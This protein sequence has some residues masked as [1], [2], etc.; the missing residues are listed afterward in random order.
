MRIKISICLLFSLLGVIHTFAQEKSIS[1]TIKNPQG[2]PQQGVVVSLKGDASRTTQTNAKGEYTI[3]AKSTDILVFSSLGMTTIERTVGEA[4]TIDVVMSSSTTKATPT[5]SSSEA[6]A[7]TNVRGPSS[8][9]GE[10]KPLWVVDGIILDDEVELSPDALSSSDAKTLIASA[11]GGLSSDDIASFKVLKDASATS[12][13]GPRAIAGVVVVNTRK[14]AKGSN[15][16]SYT[17][18][19]TFRL[20]P[21]YSNFNIMNS[22]DQMDVFMEMIR[23]GNITYV[24]MG[25][26]LHYG[27]MG[28]MYS[29]LNT[30]TPSGYGLANT[31]E[32]KGAF[33]RAAEMR[34]TDWFARLF[35]TS[36]LQ[37]HSV[38]FSTGTDKASYYA[39]VGY[40]N[41]PGWM[42]FSNYNRYTANL[43]ANY[44]LSQQVSFNLIVNSSYR[45]NKTP[46]SVDGVSGKVS[47]N[48]SLNPYS[49]ALNASRTMDPS[50]TY[51]YRYA[52]LNIFEEMENNYT[53]THIGD[54][55]IQGQLSW[56]ISPKVTAVGL[57]A[58]RYQNI[59]QELNQT[60]NSNLVRAYNAMDNTTMIKNNKYLYEDPYDDFDV[61]RSVLPEGGIREKSESLLNG[62]DFRGTIDYKDAFLGGI[63]KIQLLG[64]AETSDIYRNKDWNQNL[65]LLY[66][67][68]DMSYFSYEAF[69]QMQENKTNYYTLTRTTTRNVAFFSNAMYSYKD[70]YIVNGILRTDASNKFG[71]SRYIRWMPTW[72]L[73]FTWN[74]SQEKFFPK[75]KPISALSFKGSFGMTPES[76]STSN[77]LAKIIGERPW[78]SS[79][80]LREIALR[81]SEAANNDLT[82]EKK[83]EL[84]LGMQM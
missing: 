67:L 73:A 45:D 25:N 84:N 1:G 63:H 72:N 17:N 12:I 81:I 16:I 32:A 22:Q 65:G 30:A 7:R 31:D 38:S 35:Q 69:K 6:V 26:R 43:N 29:L 4:T 51:R 48:F 74:I 58:I 28:R 8:I 46:G 66:Q 14:G 57:A 44:K 75:L 10:S 40:I 20:I 9:Y 70:R 3:L 76:P 50:A 78:R 54:I 60:E 59:S 83:E 41:D 24:E 11:L 39:S 55:K 68:G 42:R 18:E 15:S 64:G 13:Y 33:L 5:P 2:L 56:K 49:Y 52:P 79:D 53:N 23:R 27:E 71:A 47:S 80:H 36:I 61:K 34:N 77:S 82:Y 21:S 37:S 62:K 19:S